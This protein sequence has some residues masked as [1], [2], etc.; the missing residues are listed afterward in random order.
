M[1]SQ[2]KWLKIRFAG[3]F[4]DKN[5]NVKTRGKIYCINISLLAEP[6]EFAKN[7]CEAKSKNP[8]GVASSDEIRRGAINI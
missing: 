5:S 8:S 2:N 4:A 3:F 7:N 1:L 6:S